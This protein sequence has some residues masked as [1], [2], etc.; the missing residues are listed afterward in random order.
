MVYNATDNNKKLHALNFPFLRLRQNA[1]IHTIFQHQTSALPVIMCVQ[2]GL[3]TKS[4]WG[5]SIWYICT[6]LQLHCLLPP[7][8]PSCFFCGIAPRLAN[9]YPA[10]SWLLFYTS[11]YF[12]SAPCGAIWLSKT[13][14]VWMCI[15]PLVLRAAPLRFSR[16]WCCGCCTPPLWSTAVIRFL[17]STFPG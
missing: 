5:K 15:L 2:R 1:S 17:S 6:I 7:C 14:S 16:F 4:E 12:L 10:S 11:F 13:P 9:G 8:L 3:P